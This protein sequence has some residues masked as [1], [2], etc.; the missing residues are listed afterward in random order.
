MYLLSKEDV[1]LIHSEVIKDFGGD[2]NYYHNTDERIE[3]ILS[4][5]YG[6]FGYDKYPTVF[7]K[8]A[9]LMY[10]FIKG[11]CFCDGNK[12]VGFDSAVVFLTLNGLNDN[13]DGLEGYYKTIEIAKLQ[14]R[15]E[16]ID[17]YI[18]CLSKW[19]QRRFK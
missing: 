8:A 2:P 14:L 7:D 17:R 3:S 5:Q 16:E 12:R 15:G 19:L 18:N 6:C 4:Q 11:H 9:M 10:F 1:Y 13:I